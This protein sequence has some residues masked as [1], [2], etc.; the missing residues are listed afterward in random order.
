MGLAFANNGHAFPKPTRARINNFRVC[1]VK[2][3]L[4]GVVSEVTAR[5][6]TAYVGARTTAMV[7]NA[8]QTAIS[9]APGKRH[10]FANATRLSRLHS[11]VAH[12]F[13]VHQQ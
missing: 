10:K 7:D 3:C 2:S 4:T 5:V 13:T 6:A 9:Y 11:L 1:G 12:S 8:T